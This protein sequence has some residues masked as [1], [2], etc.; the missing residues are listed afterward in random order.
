MTDVAITPGLVRRLSAG[1]WLIPILAVMAG[2]SGSRFSVLERRLGVSKS[3]LSG[4][5][6][7]LEAE[8]WI[9]RNPGH[10]H[11][12]RPEYLLTRPGRGV[13]VWCEGIIAQRQSLGLDAGVLGRW[14]LP[15]IDAIGSEWRRFSVLQRGLAPISPR[16]L[17]LELVSLCG[18]SL[19]DRRAPGPVYGLTDRGLSLA[20]TLA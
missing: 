19:I 15:L 2:E 14:S 13:A 11:P 9:S 3:V 18:A 12:L 10:G 6:G 4:T 7:R 20:A 16:A 1:R 17:S 5:L 8:G